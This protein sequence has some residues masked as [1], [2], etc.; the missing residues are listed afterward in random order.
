[1][2]CFGTSPSQCGGRYRFVVR[3]TRDYS[4]PVMI[5]TRPVESPADQILGLPLTSLW[6]ANRCRNVPPVVITYPSSSSA[7][8]VMRQETS[9]RVRTARRTQVSGKRPGSDGRANR[10]KDSAAGRFTSSR[11]T[12]RRGP[13]P[14]CAACMKPLSV[15]SRAPLR[16]RR[17]SSR[18]ASRSTPSRRPVRA[19]GSA[20]GG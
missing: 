17:A 10:S 7:C 9:T 2:R 3:Q 19:L 15:A 20:P 16:A 6:K 18:G 11:Y 8:S 14:L 13:P 4:S 1:M 12:I 5:R